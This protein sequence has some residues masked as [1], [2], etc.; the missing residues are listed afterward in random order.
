MGGAKRVGIFGPSLPVH[1]VVYHLV[2]LFY[3]LNAITSLL[4]FPRGV[5]RVTSAHIFTR[6]AFASFIVI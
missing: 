3:A 2:P 4:L 5:S 6:F 1:I